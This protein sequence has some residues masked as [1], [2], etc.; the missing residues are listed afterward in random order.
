MEVWFN[1]WW[2]PPGEPVLMTRRGQAHRP[3][4]HH[5]PARTRWQRPPYRC[6]G[7][8]PARDTASPGWVP[9]LRDMASLTEVEGGGLSAEPSW[10]QRASPVL[11]EFDLKQ[12]SWAQEGDMSRAFTPEELSERRDDGPTPMGEGLRIRRSVSFSE[13]PLPGESSQHLVD[14]KRSKSSV[15]HR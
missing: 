4:G 2:Q 1:R 15:E 13:A 7:L 5:S 10:D 14:L 3:A 8:P 9:V 11:K 12:P 6:S